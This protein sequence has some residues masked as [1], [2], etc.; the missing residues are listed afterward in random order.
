M[1]NLFRDEGSYN[2]LYKANLLENG[3]FSHSGFSYTRI[4]APVS[5]RPVFFLS[6]QISLCRMKQSFGRWLGDSGKPR[7]VHL[8][9][10]TPTIHS[11]LK[12]VQ[13]K[14]GSRDTDN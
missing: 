14:E 11:Y 8:L 7:R 10:Q 2:V 5:C 13:M 3:T 12:E 4:I 6:T 9:S 1:C